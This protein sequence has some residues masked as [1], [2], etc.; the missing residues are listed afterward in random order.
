MLPGRG[1]GEKNSSPLGQGEGEREVER[2]GG[3]EGR[4]EQ[5]QAHLSPQGFKGNHSIH[6]TQKNRE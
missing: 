6:D 4:Q 1:G 3:R 5:A 2:E